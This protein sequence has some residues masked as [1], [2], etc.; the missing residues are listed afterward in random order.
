MPESDSR[1]PVAPGKRTI[2]FD[3]VYDGGGL[4]KRGRGTI[5]LKVIPCG[6]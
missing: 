1:L 4:G 2:A 5:I 3:F 6:V